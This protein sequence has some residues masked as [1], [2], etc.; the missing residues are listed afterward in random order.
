M[1]KW[2]QY[3]ARR[4]LKSKLGKA[5]YNISLVEKKSVVRPESM[6]LKM[7]LDSEQVKQVKKNEK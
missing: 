6:A 4:Q 2:Q 1:Y 3:L 5:K 7:S